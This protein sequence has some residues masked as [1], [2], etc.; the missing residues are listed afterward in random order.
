MR[1]ADKQRF[2]CDFVRCRI[3]VLILYVSLWLYI[4]V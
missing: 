3:Y 2:V 4:I 1:R